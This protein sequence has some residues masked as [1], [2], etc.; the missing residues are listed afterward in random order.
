MVAVLGVGL[1]SYSGHGL[2]RGKPAIN[3]ALQ[4]AVT[5]EGLLAVEGVIDFFRIGATATI[6]KIDVP[7][8]IQAWP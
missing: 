7:W 3:E 4:E 8:P 1:N 5:P 2:L 6:A